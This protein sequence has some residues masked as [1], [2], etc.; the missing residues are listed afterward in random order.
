M[1]STVT[2]IID[3][4]LGRELIGDLGDRIPKCFD[5]SGCGFSQ[6]GFEF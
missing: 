4:L 5:G 1:V 2:E 6:E 3:A